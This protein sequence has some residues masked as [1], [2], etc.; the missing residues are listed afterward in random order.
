VEREMAQRAR[1]QGELAREHCSEHRAEER[2][3]VSLYQSRRP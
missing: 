3:S 2:S 1:P